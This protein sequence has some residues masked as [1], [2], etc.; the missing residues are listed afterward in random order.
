MARLELKRTMRPLGETMM[1]VDLPKIVPPTRQTRYEQSSDE[2]QE[3]LKEAFGAFAAYCT[4]AGWSD[5][6]VAVALIEIADEHL[7]SLAILADFS[8]VVLAPNLTRGP[9]AEGTSA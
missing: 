9:K 2:C 3:A 8:G 5:D 7:C 6:E 1:Q 4:A